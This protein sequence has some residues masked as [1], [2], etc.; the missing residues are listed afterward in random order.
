M[1][2]VKCAD[3]AEH[4][5]EERVG[6]YREVVGFERVRSQGGANAVHLR[7]LTGV[8]LCKACGDMRLNGTRH[9]GFGHTWDDRPLP[10]MT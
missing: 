1:P 4:V 10:G 7:R 8:V 2:Q 9:G 5:D 6:I 3:C